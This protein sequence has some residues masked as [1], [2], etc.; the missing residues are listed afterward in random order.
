MKKIAAIFIISLILMPQWQTAFGNGPGPAGM[1]LEKWFKPVSQND[2]S[3]VADPRLNPHTALRNF[4]QRR[5]FQPAWISNRG[6]LPPL[7]ALLQII[8]RAP[9]DGLRER[10]YAFWNPETASGLD[11]IF[12]YKTGRMNVPV[13]AALDVAL[14]E[15]MLRYAAHLSYGRVQPEELSALFSDN[16]KLPIRDLPGE[17]AN[18]MKD[19]RVKRFIES[20]SPHHP[21]YRTLKQ[22]LQRYRQIQADGGWPRIREGSS[23]KI[24][25]TGARVKDLH[26]YLTITGDLQADAWLP[27]NWFSPP[28]ETA[29]KRFQ[30]RHGLKA[31]GIVGRRTLTA[32]GIPVETRM[33][34]LMLNME[35][36]R[37]FPENFGSRYVIVNIPAFELRVVNNRTEALAMRVI[38]GR[39]SRPTPVLSSQLTH[40]EAN[41]YWNIPQ[42][43]AQDD[44]LEKIQDNPEYLVQQ[45]I[46]VFDSWQEDAPE[47]D[48]LEI[49]W[50]SVSKNY[51]PF[52]LRQKPT[53]RNALGRIKFMFPN[54]QSVYIHDTP[55]KSLFNETHRLFSSG[56]IR[57]EDPV[58]LAVQL[59]KD[60]HWDRRRLEK[61]IEYGQNRTI[62]LQTPFPVYLVYFTAWTDAGGDIHFSEDIYDYDRRLLLSLLNGSPSRGWCR[63][64]AVQGQPARIGDGP[65]F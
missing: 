16:E 59:L 11:A 48:P 49:D 39:K 2:A 3:I 35:R 28:L 57:V 60:R 33:I 9:Q 47:L 27:D 65:V 4:Y 53:S 50:S 32:L 64:I 34:Q 30:R 12:S 44:L 13:V 5:N 37:W 46:Q 29:V 22:T 26:R 54:S 58:A 6:P 41:P 8:H 52:R 45:G 38:V 7:A 18:A 40:L 19:N 10:D 24:G 42:K 61:Y 55:G 62:A 63:F 51:F 36:W 15:A 21:Q 23:L 25:D 14:T 1:L 20:L 31:D 43:I 17:L 56:C